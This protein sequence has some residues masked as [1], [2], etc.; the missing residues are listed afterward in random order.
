[1]SGRPSGKAPE[2]ASGDVW[3]ASANPWSEEPNK[4]EPS[5]G[6]VASGFVPGER[7]PADRLNWLHHVERRYYHYQDAIEAQNYGPA[8]ALPDFVTST[9]TEEKSFAWN[10][11]ARLHYAA[12]RDQI[13]SSRLGQAT[14][15]WTNETTGG[16]PPIFQFA[17]SKPPGLGAFTLFGG[18]DALYATDGGYAG[19]ATWTTATSVTVTDILAGA[20]V[21][22][23]S[24]WV[25]GAVYS[26][27][28][29]NQAPALIFRTEDLSGAETLLGLGLPSGYANTT[30]SGI[31]HVVVTPNGAIIAVAGQ[32]GGTA[33]VAW[34]TS[35]S[36]AVATLHRLTGITARV[37]DVWMDPNFAIDA[38]PSGAVYLLLSDGAIYRSI[39][40]GASFALLRTTTS[41]GLTTRNRLANLGGL[42]A[43]S[44]DE[45]FGFQ[46]V[47][48]STDEGE[49][50]NE[51]PYPFDDASPGDTPQIQRVVAVGARFVA[52]ANSL[53]NGDPHWISY[54]LR[55]KGLP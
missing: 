29:G 31:T 47:E 3:P 46:V 16:T 11:D 26:P 40:D 37:T 42:W 38:I 34:W 39:D 22:G 18:A 55:C 6:V 23:L 49:S 53:S 35:T 15:S 50:W 44:R 4:I 41:D 21:E 5:T 19:A 33:D 12:Y 10:A 14:A 52:V 1:M 43:R 45:S 2:W 20:W 32:T 24:R 27:S 36:T 13:Y 30:A 48:W 7:P 51:V 54:S 9:S 28:L 25:V 8:Y 17:T